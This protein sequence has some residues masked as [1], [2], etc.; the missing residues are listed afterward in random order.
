MNVY[1]TNELHFEFI[2][3][4]FPILQYFDDFVL[5]YEVGALKPF[6]EIFKTAI[7][8]ANCLPEECFFTDDRKP[9]VLGAQKIG[10]KAV[11]FLSVEQLTKS[12]QNIIGQNVSVSV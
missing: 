3:Q 10:I 8:K 5:S 2:K 9:N 6:P 4:N 11:Q 1:N 12:I 7:E